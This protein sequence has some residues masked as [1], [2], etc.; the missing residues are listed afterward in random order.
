MQNG[1]GVLGKFKIILLSLIFSFNVALA[2]KDYNDHIKIAE[3][4]LEKLE[5]LN[6]KNNKLDITDILTDLY[7]AF[8]KIHFTKLSPEE[9]G[10][11]ID[12]IYEILG[13]SIITQ[14]NPLFLKIDLAEFEYIFASVLIES[15]K[16]MDMKKKYLEFLKTF[17]Y[18]VNYLNASSENNFINNFINEKFK[19]KSNEIYKS[20]DIK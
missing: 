3:E 13:K 4:K 12:K 20:F 8:C 11:I 7:L 10:A 18:F 14:G 5:K 1:G 2:D 6:S 9:T 15:D 17:V 19:N 16:N